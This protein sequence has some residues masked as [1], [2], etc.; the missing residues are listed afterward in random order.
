MTAYLP[1]QAMLSHYAPKRLKFP[2]SEYEDEAPQLRQ[3][4]QAVSRNV[5]G[6]K[7]FLLC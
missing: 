5:T 4:P 1:G 6:K 7:K 3:H 2:I